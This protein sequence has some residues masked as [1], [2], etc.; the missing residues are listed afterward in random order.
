MITKITEAM[1][2]ECM[3]KIDREFNLPHVVEKVNSFF[4]AFGPTNVLFEETVRI[5]Q[6]VWV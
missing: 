3:G 5:S 6:C 4:T 2:T 1:G